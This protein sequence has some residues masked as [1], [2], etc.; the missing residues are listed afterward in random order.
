[1]ALPDLFN[2]F[3]CLHWIRD[4]YVR[5]EF[6]LKTP[7]RTSK[8][9]W[10]EELTWLPL[11]NNNVSMD[12]PWTSL[13]YPAFESDCILTPT[14]LNSLW[15]HRGNSDLF[16]TFFK[17][18]VTT[19]HQVWV[20]LKYVY[21]VA[22]I[23]HS[24]CQEVDGLDWNPD[25]FRQDWTAQTF[26]SEPVRYF[27]SSCESRVHTSM[28]LLPPLPLPYANRGGVSSKV[29]SHGTA[30]AKIP[31]RGFR[32]LLPGCPIAASIGPS[33]WRCITWRFIIYSSG[34]I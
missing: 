19:A 27:V 10:L 30:C 18:M 1:M 6:D 7:N 25:G 22:K 23:F 9:L 31:V 2:I 20:P 8:T 11:T 21:S 26:R 33:P 17:R 12:Q 15:C 32:I 34:W 13:F 4:Y 24:S 28:G 29:I 14:Q 16:R 5:Y 3:P